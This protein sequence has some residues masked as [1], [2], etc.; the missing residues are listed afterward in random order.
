MQTKQ[1]TQRRRKGGKNGALSAGKG[2]LGQ[3]STIVENR[4]P[5]F[6][7]R[8]TK[9]LR[10]STNATL[11]ATSG[12]VATYVIRANDLFDPDFTS[13]GH[14]PMGFDQMMVFYNHFC[15]THAKIKV[16]YHAAA[17]NA[18]ACVGAIRVDANSTAITSIDQIIEFG[19]LAMTTLEAK[20]SFGSSK[21]LE[22]SV[23][24]AKLQGLTESTMLADSALRGNAAASPTEITYF[25]IAI[26]DAGATTA[27]ANI[28]IVMEQ[29]AVFMEPRD[30]T[31]SSALKAPNVKLDPA[32]HGLSPPVVQL[33]LPDEKSTWVD[34]NN[35]PF[36][37]ADHRCPVKGC[38]TPYPL[39]N[40]GKLITN[41]V[42]RHAVPGYFNT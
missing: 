30:I 23:S 42:H 29:R 4:M 20:A 8:T 22:L 36:D 34:I 18:A 35:M 39:V 38:A 5:L 9:W 40:R 10:Y 28:D 16:V 1:K 2:Q 12:T 26:W 33:D 6:P 25:H 15:V 3:L 11:T 32:L 17:A 24:V 37:A 19:G 13:T 21:E 14:Q 27:A 7:A 41:C 31:L